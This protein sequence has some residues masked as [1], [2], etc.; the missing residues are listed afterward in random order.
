MW[1]MVPRE[2]TLVLALAWLAVAAAP[3]AG[4]GFDHAAVDTV[5]ER[6]VQD[7]RVDYAALKVGR[8]VL[9]GYLSQVAAVTAQE[10]ESWPAKERL[11]YLI[12]AYNAYVLHTIVDH[13]PI[14]GSGFFKKLT[15]PKRFTLP[16][17]SIRHI[18]GVFDGIYHE[19][20]GREMTLDDIVHGALRADYAEPR[21]HFALVYGAVS[22]PPLREEAFRGDRLDEQLD[23]QA[24]LFLNDPRLNRFEVE[25]GQVHLSQIFEWF[26]DDFRGFASESGYR[27]NEKSNGVLAFASR[28][29]RER[30]ASYL[31]TGEYRVH[32]LS[33]DWTLNDQAVAAATQ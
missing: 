33:Y 26:G 31:E 12:N 8:E 10:F 17:N 7:G 3:A 11:A 23:D 22:C 24:R 27:S 16:G 32:F 25:R 21:I 4:Q 30:V 18:D 29:V 20:A 6:F 13:Y 28:Y 15:S 9:D 14:T 2:G 1:T 19:V 5:L